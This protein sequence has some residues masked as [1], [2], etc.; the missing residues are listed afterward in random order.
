MVVNT[1]EEYN[2]FPNGTIFNLFLEGESW[3]EEFCKVERVIKVGDHLLV[4]KEH[5]NFSENNDK[6]YETKLI[7][8]EQ[9][10]DYFK[11]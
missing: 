9:L 5:Y 1:Q 2:K 4:L 10:Q 7:Y 3:D 6:G 11:M 8:S